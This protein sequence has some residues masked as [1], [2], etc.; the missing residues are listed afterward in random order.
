[1]GIHYGKDNYS[2]RTENKAVKITR[3]IVQKL[4]ESE[5]NMKDSPLS[6]VE[7]FSL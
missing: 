2:G 5:I 4:A 3:N 1:M 6:S 7:Y